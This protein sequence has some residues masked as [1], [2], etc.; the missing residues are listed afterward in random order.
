[1]T[2]NG[3][4]FNWSHYQIEGQTM[5]VPALFNYVFQRDNLSTGN[6]APIQTLSASSLA[7]VDPQYATYQATGNWRVQTLWSISCT[8]SISKYPLPATTSVRSSKSNGSEKIIA[9][10]V[11]K[12][13][14]NFY[15]NIFPNPTAEA[16]TLQSSENILEIEITDMLG[17][18]R[19]SENIYNDNSPRIDCHL[20]N[21]VYFVH[22]KSA[23]GVLVKKIII[24]N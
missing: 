1:M 20:T 24:N 19:Y 5:P 21:G 14:P 23:K 2:N 9:T 6:W 8:P 13:D 17:D 18:K 4:N 12:P 7:Y 16:F 3:G 22:I 11:N 15:T 10:G